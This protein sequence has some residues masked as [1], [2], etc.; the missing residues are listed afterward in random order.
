M[1]VNTS[2]SKNA[3]SFYFRQSFIDGNGKS[4]SRTIRRLGTLNELLVEHGPTRDD[5]MAWAKK[6]ARIETEKY[7]LEKKTLS[8]P[9]VFHPNRKIPHKKQKCFNGGKK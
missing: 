6:Q 1:K 2:K 5:V 9:V 7:K 3:E 8:I 4:T